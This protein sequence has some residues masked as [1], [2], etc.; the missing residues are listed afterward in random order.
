VYEPP[1]PKA[2]SGE[3]A[4]KSAKETAEDS[5]AKETK[6]HGHV[7]L[8]DSAFCVDP[9]AAELAN[10]ARTTDYTPN[11]I[12]EPGLAGLAASDGQT[13]THAWKAVPG[14][15]KGDHDID[16]PESVAGYLILGVLGRGGMGVVYKALQPGLKRLVA[17]KMIL[18]GEYA[19]RREVTRFRSEAETV[20]QLQHVNI[21]QIYE[22]GEDAGRPYFSLEFIDGVSLSKKVNG[23][24]L[25]PRE[26]AELLLQLAHAVAYAHQKGIIHRDIKPANVLLTA[27]GIPKLTDFGLAKRVQD[28]SGQTRTGTVLGTPSYMPPEQAEGRLHEVG[29]RSDVYS[30]GAVLYDMLTG[31]PP[32]RGTTVL[33]TLQMVQKQ[34]PVA[35]TELQPKVPRDLQ[36]ICLTCLHKEPARRYASAAALAEDLRRFLTGEPILARPAGAGERLWRWCRRNPRVAALSAALAFLLVIWAITSSALYSIA[37]QNE[38]K[39]QENETTAIQEADRAQKNEQKAIEEAARAQANA[40][41]ARSRQQNA[42]LAMVSLGGELQ[43]RLRSRRL[44]EQLGPQA[45]LMQQQLIDVL[46]TKMLE[47]AGE[48]ESKG[49]RSFGTVALHQQ[50][51]DLLLKFGQG[52][53]AL[54]QYEEGCKIIRKDVE[55]QPNNDR[56]RANL[57]IMM[58]RLGDIALEVNGDAKAARDYYQKGWDLQNEV[59]V[60]PH[61]RDFPVQQKTIV[62]SHHALH[63]GRACL[64]MGRP[65]EAAKHFEE[66]RKLRQEWALAMAR[67]PESRGYLVEV[68]M[69]LGTAAWHR[70]DAK[71]LTQYFQEALQ[72]METLIKESP[73]FA[74]FKKDLAEVYAAHAEGLMH[75]GR[76][77]EA[78][79]SYQHAWDNLK[80]FME[81]D[82][83][84]PSPLPM[85]ALLH[86]R[87]GA[88]A[89]RR[90]QQPEARKYYQEALNIRQEFTRLEPENRV[91]QAAF[92]LALARCGKHVEAA[93]GADVLRPQA[94][95]SAE[96]LL[97]LARCYAVCASQD[98]LS[99]ALE[100]L[101]ELRALDYRDPVVVRTDPDLAALRTEA[102]F[103]SLLDKWD[104]ERK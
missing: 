77:D 10:P 21:V 33:D 89:Q 3:P 57:G 31:R 26:A 5:G 102:A 88:D 90:G 103:L 32:F 15:R 46:R 16:L 1:K 45:R 95:N 66:A 80:L 97:Q 6:A 91:C 11:Q 73:R 41:T 71:A 67:N 83:N 42:F 52:K 28:E 20:A 76:L 25:P 101:R 8:S 60:H 62:L 70:E 98:S 86:E 19:G 29:P 75:L 74:D 104:K 99:K 53:Q 4:V 94:A 69:W 37:A 35:P 30:L 78:R 27:D 55:E 36:T 23:T 79:T 68:N 18:A 93:R 14:G 9:L 100:T 12:N 59:C 48:S 13:T 56:A 50:L 64:A 84:D 43:K 72:L 96:L 44:S 85:L 51:G 81:N 92:L 39:A 82:P 2:S 34:E 47:I 87:L 54:R 24:P 40:E 22:V 17:L 49:V 58:M 63:L 7:P 38:R 61:D 65:A